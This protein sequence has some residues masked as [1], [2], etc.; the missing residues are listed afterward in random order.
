MTSDQLSAIGTVAIVACPLAAG[1]FTAALVVS[2]A[3]L[4][5]RRNERDDRKR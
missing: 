1:V 5:R 4:N 2:A 3:A